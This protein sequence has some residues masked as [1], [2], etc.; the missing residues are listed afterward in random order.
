MKRHLFF[1]AIVIGAA[2]ADPV[3]SDAVDALGPET[4]GIKA[5]PRHRSGQNCTTCHGTVYTVSPE[6]SVGG[7][8][9]KRQ[10]T[11]EAANGAVVTITDKD[12]NARTFVTNDVGNFFA[13][14]ESYDPPF[15]LKVKVSFVDE[16][17]VTQEQEMLTPIRRNAGCGTCH[18]DAPN[19]DSTHMRRIWV[20]PEPKE[21]GP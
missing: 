11:R 7:T 17:G 20:V 18:L 3:H 15:P 6:I 2:C 1:F 13:P 14:K 10:S 19:G 5:G 12:G 8:V 4:D 16:N 21:A 9:F